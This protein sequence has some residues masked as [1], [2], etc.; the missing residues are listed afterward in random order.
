[1]VLS[2]LMTLMRFPNTPC[3]RLALLLAGGLVLLALVWKAST[4]WN[5]NPRH[6]AGEAIDSLNGVTVYFNGAVDHCEERN[7]A[8]DG[9]NL[10]IKHQCVEFVKRYYYEH[11]HH[12]MPDSFG[13]AREFFNPALTDG[14]Y[15]PSRDLVQYTNGSQSRPRPDD[16]LVFGPTFLNEYGHVAIVASV[17][18]TEV[19]IVE[20]NTGAFGPSRERLPIR[21]E[22]GKWKYLNSQVLGWLRKEV[23][24]K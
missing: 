23:D 10:G 4:I 13:H 5:L 6:Q 19:E 17:S 20:Q 15:S 1:M 3:R 12:K 16:L 24:G 14:M 18:D 2:P 11:L 22:Q 7:L 8:P 21:L 9:Y